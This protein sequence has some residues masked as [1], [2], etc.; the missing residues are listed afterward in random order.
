MTDPFTQP[1]EIAGILAFILAAVIAIAGFLRWLVQRNR[2]DSSP[3]L[4][5]ADAPTQVNVPRDK[6]HTQLAAYG[7]FLNHGEADAFDARVCIYDAYVESGVAQPRWFATRPIQVPRRTD[8]GPG[9]V[10]VQDDG[11]EASWSENVLLGLAPGSQPNVIV[12]VLICRG[13]SG[14]NRYRFAPDGR[15]L[16]HWH[17]RWWLKWRRPRWAR[18]EGE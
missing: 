1:A 11:S 13:A 15:Q 4:A 3:R 6:P 5:L 2:N 8:L 12:K 18:W 16:S 17:D 9:K 14:N 10:P 7:F